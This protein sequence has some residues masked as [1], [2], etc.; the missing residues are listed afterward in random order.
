MPVSR[1]SLGA[2]VQ[3]SLIHQGAEQEQSS[4]TENV[5][6]PWHPKGILQTEKLSEVEA[7]PSQAL[8]ADG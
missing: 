5:R 8:E 1:I 3:I 6:K 4:T 2:N 7:I